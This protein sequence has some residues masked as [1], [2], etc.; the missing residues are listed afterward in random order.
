[1]FCKPAG[2]GVGGAFRKRVVSSWPKTDFVLPV[3]TSSPRI[4]QLSFL[5]WLVS[6]PLSWWQKSNRTGVEVRG[7][8]GN[9]MTPRAAV[10][11]SLNRLPLDC[12]LPLEGPGFDGLAARQLLGKAL[13]VAARHG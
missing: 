10:R 1:M 6:L 11:S 9:E 2:P 8:V 13:S 3:C 12:E 7:A 5:F 4:S